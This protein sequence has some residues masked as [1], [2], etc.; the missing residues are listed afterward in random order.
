M[1]SN[2]FPLPVFLV[3]SKID[4]LLEEYSTDTEVDEESKLNH[5]HQLIRSESIQTAVISM[6]EINQFSDAFI[7][8]ALYDNPNFS[9]LKPQYYSSS[10]ST[11]NYELVSHSAF[12]KEVIGCLKN[13][14]FFEKVIRKKEV[15]KVKQANN[16]ENKCIIF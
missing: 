10:K 3:I 13:L 12:A 9:K 8:S 15:S 7:F 5:L 16:N 2:G 6:V 1:L 11:I 14:D 4:C